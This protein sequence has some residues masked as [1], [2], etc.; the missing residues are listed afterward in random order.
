MRITL[1]TSKST[2]G[3]GS[4]TLLAGFSPLPS[5]IPGEKPNLLFIITD[6]QR[7]D[8]LGY[9]GND[10]I[11]T[12]EMDRLASEGTFF[13][14]AFVTTPIC[15]ASRAS[16]MT[17]LYEREH[18]FTFGTPPLAK[19]FVD[20]SYPALLK[21]HGYTNGYV[22]KFGMQFE[23]SLDTTLFEY[24]KRPGEQFRA[25][26]YYRLSEGNTKHKH[27]TTEIGDLSLDFIDQFGDGPFCLTVSFHAPHAEDLDPRQYIYPLE[28]DSLYQDVTIPGPALSDDRFFEEQ[29]PWVRNGFNRD[30]WY[31]RFDTP[32]KYQQMVKGYYRMISG[33]DREIGRIRRMLAETGLSDNTVIILIGDNGYFLGE[34]QLAGKWLMYDNSLRVPLIVYQPGSRPSIQEGMALNIDVPATLIDFAGI[35]L[36]E[37]MSGLSLKNLVTGK[38]STLERDHFLCE[39]WMKTPKIPKSEGI[40]TEKWKYFRYT[41]HPEHE[42]LYDL[43]KDSLEIRNLARDPKY[44]GILESMRGLLENYPQNK[45]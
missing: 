23:N 15:A 5:T 30:R 31:W 4:L 24:Y 16:L 29:P 28:L 9:A 3:L 6:D 20:I 33:V 14:N 12:P 2:L 35:P 43:E 8:A 34:R 36:P 45:D 22:G 19:E 25:T 42:E 7:W 11:Y 1:T 40:R 37:K 41:D 17:G 21:K 18:D 10:I 26:T 44:T 27:L 32:E 39:H 13:R 38:N